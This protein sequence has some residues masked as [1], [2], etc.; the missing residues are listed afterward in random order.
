[1]KSKV[2]EELLDLLRTTVLARGN[3][4]GLPNAYVVAVLLSG[5]SAEV[6]TSGNPTAATFSP[7]AKIYSLYIRLGREGT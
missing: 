1:M 2:G 4:N 7:V 5:V 6:P 3:L